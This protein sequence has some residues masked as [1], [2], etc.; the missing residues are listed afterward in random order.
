MCSFSTVFLAPRFVGYIFNE[1]NY[2]ASYW[3]LLVDV[4]GLLMWFPN[5][6]QLMLSKYQMVL[7]LLLCLVRVRYCGCYTFYYYGISPVNAFFD[8]IW[9]NN[10][11]RNGF[12][13]FDDLPKSLLI[14]TNASMG[15]RNGANNSC[16]RNY[17]KF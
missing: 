10:N 9:N 7:L 4:L 14:K 17:A 12:V 2:L 11:G 1:I 5:K 15:W 3:F 8:N 6:T 16:G 13:G